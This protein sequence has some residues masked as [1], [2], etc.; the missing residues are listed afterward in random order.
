MAEAAKRLK[1]AHA[2]A[3]KT[4]RK[5]IKSKRKIPNKKK[6]P[7]PFVSIFMP[8]VVAMFAKRF[9]AEVNRLS[10][11]K[12]IIEGSS[13]G[14]QKRSLKELCTMRDNIEALLN[15]RE[16]LNPDLVTGLEQAYGQVVYHINHYEQY[17]RDDLGVPDE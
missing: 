7:D 16:W 15:N 3:K 1:R 2:L 17:H 11:G 12:F 6:I 10:A 14:I 9:I 4:V 13:M 8:A 5:S